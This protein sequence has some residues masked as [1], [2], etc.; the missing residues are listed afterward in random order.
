MI[1]RPYGLFVEI[2][3]CRFPALQAGLSNMMGF[4]PLSQCVAYPLMEKSP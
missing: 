4:S 3:L 1:V 2:L